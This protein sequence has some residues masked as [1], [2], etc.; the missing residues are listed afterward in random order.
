MLRLVAGAGAAAV[1]GGLAIAGEAGAVGGGQLTTTT[2]LNLRSGPGT[3]RRVLRVI[4]KGAHV[5]DHGTVRNGFRLVTYADTRGW[6]YDQY[7]K[8]GTQVPGEVGPVIGTATTTTAVN[9]RSGPSTGDG[10]IRVVAK[11]SS[12]E[13]TDTVVDGFRYVY[14]QGTGGWIY[15]AYLAPAGAG[16][17]TAKPY[18]TTAAVNLREQPSTSARIIMV[19]PAGEIVADYDLVLQNGF[20]GVEYQGKTGW[21][22]DAY[23]QARWAI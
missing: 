21:I 22:S 8:A 17:P 16:D 3:N 4:P 10:V 7:L 11:G 2:A 9:F 1:V 23:L 20:R 6:A 12:V 14:H 19:V 18:M 5:F 15:D 13:I